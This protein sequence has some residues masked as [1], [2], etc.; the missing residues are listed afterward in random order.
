LEARARSLASIG[1]GNGPGFRI[2]EIDSVIDETG[3]T[4]YYDGTFAFDPLLSL[5]NESAES[6]KDS[7]ARQL[8]LTLELRRTPG[9]VLVVRS[10]DRT[11]TEN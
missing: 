8:G 9:K 3:L 10:A 6:L 2:T 5:H 4:G 1:S 11:P 7:V